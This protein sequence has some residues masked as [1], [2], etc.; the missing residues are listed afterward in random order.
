M[1]ARAAIAHFEA[2]AE[3]HLQDLESLVRIPSCSF[4]GHDPKHVRDSADATAALLVRRGFQNVRLLELPGV[5]PYVF[6]ELRVDPRAP[7]ILLYAHHDV[8]P[9]GDEKAWLSPP[10]EP[11]RRDGRLY[12]RG[13]ADDKAGVSVHAAAVDAWLRGAGKLPVNLEI[14]VEGE[15]EIGSAHLPD[16]LRA[17]R[18]LFRADVMV[19]TDT[20]NFDTGLPS[21]TTS[22]RGLC[23]VEVT[24][25]STRTAL[26]SG[27]WSGPVPDAA[28]ALARTLAALTNPDGSIAIPGFYDKVRGLSE[29]ERA[30]IAALP[31]TPAEFARQAGMVAGA[32]LLGGPKHPC[33][34]NWRLP[35]LTVH[36]M[37]ASGRHEAR[38]ILTGS[39]WAQLGVRIVPDMDPHETRA[40][41][42]RALREAA[43][44][45][46]EVEVTGEK[47]SGAWYCSPE[48]PA[49]DAAFRALEKGYG[50]KAIAMGCGASIPFVGPLSEALGGVPALLIGVEDPYTNAHSENES[51]SL[52]DWHS[53]CRSA[54]YLYEELAAAMKKA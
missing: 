34:V 21:L 9:P 35:S 2:R 26:H 1:N 37:Q 27:L 3:E 17:Y 14:L 51:L 7:T 24:V 39:A 40:L 15:E 52:S 47:A 45:G 22:L 16:F 30:S 53:A 36:A 29:L 11:T 43:P 6:G 44:W 10:Y 12:G 41:L 54:I 13:T 4:A 50:R 8:Q 38:N 49:F 25:R 5:H 33:E 32:Q 28:M 48:H 23:T 42:E 19:L 20:A 31:T 18:E 46:V